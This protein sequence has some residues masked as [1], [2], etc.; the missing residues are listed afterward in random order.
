MSI[1]EYLK[2][3]RL[4]KGLE[5]TSCGLCGG[6]HSVTSYFMCGDCHNGWVNYMGGD[7]HARK[8]IGPNSSDSYSPPE[9]NV[10]SH[11]NT[12]A[13]KKQAGS[14]DTSAGEMNQPKAGGTKAGP[15]SKKDGAYVRPEEPATH[16]ST[17]SSKAH[18]AAMPRKE[19]ASGSTSKA[20]AGPMRI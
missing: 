16:T 2:Q 7:E 19:G 6:S 12:D 13:Y 20:P 4:R 3:D 17:N 11:S 5:P 10:V 18:S 1:R 14:K 9:G 15:T 8:F